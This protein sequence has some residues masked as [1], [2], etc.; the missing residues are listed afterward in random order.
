[1]HGET[2]SE[3]AFKITIPLDSFWVCSFHDKNTNIGGIVVGVTAFN[4]NVIYSGIHNNATVKVEG[5]TN[6]STKFYTN[7][8]DREYT[9]AIF[10]NYSMK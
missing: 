5:N 1:M 7:C 2:D 9:I 10:K 3:G 4:S 8:S 6:D